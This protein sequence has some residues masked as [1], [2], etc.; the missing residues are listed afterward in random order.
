LSRFPGQSSQV[1]SV[2]LPLTVE[3]YVMAKLASFSIIVRKF[4]ISRLNDRRSPLH[5]VYGNSEALIRRLRE[6]DG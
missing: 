5:E 3:L 4:E 1:D 6:L 2:E